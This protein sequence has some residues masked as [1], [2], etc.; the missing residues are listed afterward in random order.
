MSSSNCCFLILQFSQ[1]T[2][3]VVWY[4]HLLKNFP[5]CHDLQNQRFL[6]SQWSRSRCFL[7]S[8]CFF[9]NPMDVGSL[10]SGSSV[11]SKCSLNIWKFL[12]HIL[13]K[14]TWEDFEHY[15]T[16]MWNECISVDRK[17]KICLEYVTDSTK[18]SWMMQNK[19]KKF[20]SFFICICEN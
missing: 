10:I 9:Y 8:P 19:Y 3:K 13:L 7:E 18:E 20:K 11:F 15:L 12:V 2:G 16:S 1:E 5:F 17:F 4:S 14:P 6:H